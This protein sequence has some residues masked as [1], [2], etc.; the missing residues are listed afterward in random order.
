MNI[1]Y[2]QDYEELVISSGGINGICLLGAL[3]VCYKHNILKNVKYYTGCS[4]GAVICSL[5]VIGYTLDE[6]NKIIFNIDFSKF[7]DLKISNFIEKCGM[8]DGAKM[9]NLLKATLLNRNI[10]PLITFKELYEM[11]NKTLT[12]AVTNITNGLSEYHNYINTPDYSVL[13]SL[14]MSINVPMIFTPI[15]F[16]DCYYVDGA[17]LDPF[18]YLYNKNISLSKKCGLCL[19]DQHELPFMKNNNC[20]IIK[21]LN[22]TLFYF[23]DLIKILEINHLKKHH[24]KTYKNVIYIDY[25]FSINNFHN[26]GMSDDIKNK[27]FLHGVNKA[28]HFFYNKY[29][30]TFQ[31]K[32]K[33]YLL[34]K[35]FDH[36]KKFIEN[37]SLVKNS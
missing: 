14:R 3:N 34:I 17:L 8:D 13:L 22:N 29:K 28:K 30:K 2:N 36:W 15:I 10:N 25:N 7:Q 21:E 20:S 26:F 27:S 4:F 12:F 31:K 5:L 33:T 32:Q 9:H 23:F 16:K 18:P 37:N 24:K 1:D 6:I 11:T 19:F 35:Y